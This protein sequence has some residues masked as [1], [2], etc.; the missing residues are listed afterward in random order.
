MK[1][2]IF[3]A[4]IIGKIYAS[5]IF[6]SGVDVTLFA[7]NE[8][9]ETIKQ[10]GYA[11]KNV[12]TSE[13]TDCLIPVTS[14]INPNDDYDLI[15]VTVRLDQFNSVGSSLT[16]FKSV[17]AIMFM[18][19]HIQNLEELPQQFQHGEIILGFPGVGGILKNKVIEYI[20][21]KQQKTTLGNLNGHP[22]P[23]VEEI[24]EI[25]IKS[26]FPTVLENNM[27]GWLKTHA[28]FITC[29]SAA[30]MK[31]AG[32][33]HKLGSNKKAVLEMVKSIREGF[34][35]L[36]ELG[37][38]I[39]PKNLKTIFLTMPDWFAVWYWKKSMRGNLGTLA[40]AP[41]AK[42][43]KSEMQL[44]AK[45]VLDLVHASSHPAPTLHKL[46]HDF[47]KDRNNYSDN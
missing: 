37:I 13:I 44:L 17:K 43:A 45:N 14:V 28:V 24:K 12:L 34:L 5:L 32:S 2:L 16:K 20:Q 25:L 9:Y 36:Q 21:I 6:K 38:E 27:T 7:R 35:C 41:H 18:L 30:I 22:S 26:G 29:A 33:N 39:T 31:Q 1:I 40:I 42:V 47:I 15:I 3:G 46:L 19:N 4:G 11:I 10:N 23:L 8:N